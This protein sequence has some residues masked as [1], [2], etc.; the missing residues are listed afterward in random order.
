MGEEEEGRNLDNF[1]KDL[2]KCCLTALAGGDIPG[3]QGPENRP[4]SLFFFVAPSLSGNGAVKA[5]TLFYLLKYQRSPWVGRCITTRHVKAYG[6]RA[7]ERTV[8]GM[9]LF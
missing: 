9:K 5:L 2:E 4:P 7:G 8:G 6:G 1:F 3:A